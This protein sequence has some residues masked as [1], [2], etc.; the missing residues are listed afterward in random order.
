MST[1]NSI[2]ARE[3]ASAL[4][5]AGKLTAS[6]ASTYA[7]VTPLAFAGDVVVAKTGTGVYTITINP[8]KGPQGLVRTIVALCGATGCIEIDS[9]TYTNDSL[10]VTVKTYAVDGS[11]ATNK[12]FSFDI[13]AM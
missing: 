11:T 3:G 2:A 6:D 4:G 12:A 7:I 8:F 13:L 9:E 10:V 1:R 5:V